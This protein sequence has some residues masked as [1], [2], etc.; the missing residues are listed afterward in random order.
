MPA[1][2]CRIMPARNISRCEAISAS[3]GVSF[4][5]GR[6]KRDRRIEQAQE[7]GVF[8]DLAT[9]TGRDGKTQGT[10]RR[11]IPLQCRLRAFSQQFEHASRT[12]GSA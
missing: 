10:H 5:I 6:K 8:A 4:R 7:S 11:E 9:E 3:F 2:S 12:T 1:P